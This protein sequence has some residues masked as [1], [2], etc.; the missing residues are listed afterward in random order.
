MLG[1]EMGIHVNP[2]PDK[3]EVRTIGIYAQ[4]GTP[5]AKE[6]EKMKKM[7]DHHFHP[8]DGKIRA[9]RGED[10]GRGSVQCYLYDTQMTP[11]GKP[12]LKGLGMFHKG[13]GEQRLRYGSYHELKSADPQISSQ[14]EKVIQAGFSDHSNLDKEYVE[15]VRLLD[16]Q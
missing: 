5:A 8:V 15:L 3:N 9:S 6:L 13:L 7:H 1:L 12:D 10:Q 16:I 4:N 2:T 11:T 14:Y